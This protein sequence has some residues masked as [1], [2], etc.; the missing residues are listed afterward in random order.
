[1]KGSATACHEVGG[2][3]RKPGERFLDP[4]IAASVGRAKE[5]LHKSWRFIGK[6]IGVSHSHLV[7]IAQGKRVPSV[8]V[9]EAMKAM[10]FEAGEY[11]RLHKAAV[12]GRGRDRASR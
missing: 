8:V 10:P 11:E 5:R 7:L 1:V 9:A 2:Y 3:P 4:E 12:R 6:R